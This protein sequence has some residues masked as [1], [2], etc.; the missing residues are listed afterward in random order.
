MFVPLHGQAQRTASHR[1]PYTITSTVERVLLDV[2]VRDHHGAYVK[3]LKR[4]DFRVYE[5]GRRQPITDFESGDTPVTVG[6][7]LDDSASMRPKRPEVVTAGLAF[8]KE[9]NPK[10][11]FFVVNFNNSVLL[12]LPRAMPFTDNLQELRHALYMGVPIGQ[13]ALYDAIVFALRHLRRGREGKKTLIVVSDGGDNVST[14]SLAQVLDDV[15]ASEATIY[16]IGVFDSGDEDRN[17]SVLRKLA[18]I[19]GGEFFEAAASEKIVPVFHEIAKD[20]RTR[21]TIGFAPDPTLDPNK[22]PVRRIRVAV[23][24][25]SRGKLTVRTRRQYTFKPDAGMGNGSQ[26]G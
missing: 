9:S 25:P 8:A 4:R 15:Q 19:S 21:Y 20:I 24:D 3:G 6:L 17:P 22:T 23:D 16:T 11:Q 18:R 1:R 10:D 14:H 26:A 13:T 2:S 5:D 12:G 7:V